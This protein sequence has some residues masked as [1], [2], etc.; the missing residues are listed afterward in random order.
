MRTQPIGEIALSSI[1][2]SAAPVFANVQVEPIH[3]S[4]QKVLVTV[5]HDH[6]PMKDAK[7]EVLDAGGNFRKIA[8]YTDDAGNARLPLLK[9]GSYHVVATADVGLHADLFLNVSKDHK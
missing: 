6:L 3:S 1:C 7:V 2:V 9:P 4:S 5:L 8:L